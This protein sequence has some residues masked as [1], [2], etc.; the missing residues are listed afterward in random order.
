MSYQYLT[1][2]TDCFVLPRAAQV[3]LNLPAV[4]LSVHEVTPAIQHLNL[5]PSSEELTVRMGRT[6]ALK[7]MQSIETVSYGTVPRDKE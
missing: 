3:D 5:V 2:K 1:G 6:H 7:C 4:L